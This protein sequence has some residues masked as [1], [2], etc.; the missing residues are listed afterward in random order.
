MSD[1]R[2]CIIKSIISPGDYWMTKYYEGRSEVDALQEKLS[3]EIRYSKLNC[4]KEEIASGEV[5][6]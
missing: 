3:R 6:P 2:R 4:L 1:L 5:S